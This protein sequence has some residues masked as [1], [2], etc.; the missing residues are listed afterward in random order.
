MN[1]IIT[2]LTWVA[3]FICSNL[4]AQPLSGVKTIGGMS[5]D[6]INFTA[7]INS[8]NTNGVGTGGVVFDVAAGHVDTAINLTITATGT[9]SNPIVI[10]KSG[11]GNNPIIYAGLGTS[12]TTDGIL[13]LSGTDYITIDGIDFFDHP[14][15]NTSNTTRMEWG[16]AILKASTSNGCQ[17]VVIRNCNFTLQKLNTASKAIY[18]ANHTPTS[19][20]ALTISALSGINANIEI[21]GNTITNSFSAIYF[22][23]STNATYFDDSIRIGSLGRNI[24][25]DFGGSGTAYGV[26]LQY[27]KNAEIRND[28]IYQNITPTASSTHYGIYTGTTTN[29]NVSIAQNAVTLSI[30]GSQSTRAVFPI[31]VLSG[32]AGNVSTI[33][34]N[35]ITNTVAAA[36][37]TLFSAI[38]TS[39]N[40]NTFIRGNY[41][42]GYSRIGTSGNTQIIYSGLNP[43]IRE[44][45]GNTILNITT[46][47][48][49]AQLRI[50]AVPTGGGLVANNLINTTNSSGTSADAWIIDIAGNCQFV[51]NQISNIQH[52]SSST[53][54]LFVVFLTGGNATV[55]D[56]TINTSSTAGGLF[57]GIEL[58]GASGTFYQVYR[59]K[60]FDFSSTY[61]S[62]VVSAIRQSNNN[63]ATIFNN[64]IGS[65]ASGPSSTTANG[66]N[67]INCS[68][69]GNAELKL[70]HNTIYLNATSTG[71][72]NCVLLNTSANA[73]LANNLF[74]NLSA[75]S[76]TNARAACA[77]RRT[78]TTFN[79]YNDSS[80]NNYFYV[81][82]TPTANRFVY[83]DG[84]NAHQTIEQFQA[85]AINRDQ[86][87]VSS[88]LNFMSVSGLSP[89][90]LKPVD[91]CYIESAGKRIAGING[92][93][94]DT[95]SRNS[96]PLSGQLNG[97]GLF[98]DIGAYEL[99]LLFLDN[100]KPSIVYTPITRSLASPSKAFDNVSITDVSGIN[101][102]TP[103][104]VYFKKKSN[105][106]VLAATNSALDN[107]WK[108]TSTFNTGSPFSF[109]LDYS[110]LFPNGTVSAGDT[111]EYFIVA[112]DNSPLNNTA[113][114]GATLSTQPVA[115]ALAQAQFPVSNAAFYPILASSIS[116]IITVGTSFAD[117]SSLTL[118][119]G[120]FDAINNGIVAGDITAVVIT[121]L[122]NETGQ[123]A[124]NRFYE[125]G[126]APGT[127]KLTI[128][129]VSSTNYTIS[130]INTT[131]GIL[132]FNDTRRV[133]INGNVSGFTR[134]FTIVNN[135]TTG[136][137]AAIQI[138]GTLNGGG[139]SDIE[140]IG[141]NLWTENIGT[142]SSVVCIGGTTVGTGTG[143]N[144][145]VSNKRITI[146]NNSIAKAYNG[147]LVNGLTGFWADSIRIMNN[148]IG[149]DTV[150][151]YLLS[152]GI[153]IRGAIRTGIYGNRIF[154][155]K[156]SGT[157]TL[158][159]INLDQECTFT[160]VSANS[161]EKI[162]NLAN[163]AVPV[164]GIYSR[165]NT[166]AN[167]TLRNNRISSIL[168]Q[169]GSGDISVGPVGI[170]F[171]NGDNSAIVNNTVLLGGTRLDNTVGNAYTACL[172][173]RSPV[174]N[175]NVSN[176][177][178]KNVMNSLNT[179]SAGN[180]FAIVT[181]ANNA[182]AFTR[183]DNNVYFVNSTTPGMVN[184]LA[185]NNTTTRTNLSAWRSFSN[186]D[187]FSLWGNAPFL[188]DST[189]IVVPSDSNAWLMNGRGYPFDFNGV[190]YQ[191]NSRSSM[192]TTGAVDIGADEF[193]PSVQPPVATASAIPASGQTTY[194]SFGQDTIAEIFWNPGGSVPTDLTIRY[195]S[196]V[197][198][199]SVSNNNHLHTYWSMSSNTNSGI[200]YN[201]T[202]YYKPESMNGI[203]I[204]SLLTL[205]SYSNSQWYAYP[206]ASRVVDSGNKKFTTFNLL[207]FTTFT[208]TD[209][210]NPLP[211]KLLD[212][213]AFLNDKN[214]VKLNW[215]T[216]QHQNVNAFQVE[217]GTD[218]KLFQ[219]IGVI[220]VTES[221]Y[222]SL[223]HYEYI[224]QYPSQLNYYRLK[225]M[226][227]DGSFAYSPIV[228]VNK[229]E[230]SISGEPVVI[231]PVPATNQL[232]IN[233]F[234]SSNTKVSVYNQFGQL[235]L[236]TLVQP[237]AN[238]IDISDLAEGIY[239]ISLQAKDNEVISKK[240]I[241]VKP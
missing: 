211:L 117:Y 188:N 237:N 111:I 228:V 146:S 224:H 47:G 173:V 168:G 120:L 19:T 14:T 123:I 220:P 3:L 5:P 57:N 31:Y 63:S 132:R 62:C 43:V 167:I 145:G 240:I 18:A 137:N 97:G 216:T 160:D 74:M 101:T 129:P 204:D 182:T 1:R 183:I 8:L 59:N 85:Y 128:Q 84:T 54:E 184:A 177:V 23:G 83:T 65:I 223:S 235:V 174:S 56:N 93:F 207:D 29:A 139:A 187:K 21:H 100:K 44:I 143:A 192:M 82:A 127:Y 17:N 185:L 225:I 203:A 110:L 52:N 232:T 91:T 138:M 226:D 219:P 35:R 113:V 51:K 126:T 90:F 121:D 67:G 78:S 118:P 39:T 61:S 154:N 214:E 230:I 80:D 73:L 191:S 206:S 213:T 130:G 149:T 48:T 6:F 179:I 28:S 147:I 135:A 108:F 38:Y 156:N 60:I 115:V 66:I 107:G 142:G 166:N 75:N 136:A 233:N 45:T 68:A 199:P 221:A 234:A 41:I 34:S 209:Y 77:L 148:E 231:Y 72:S 164:F 114:S 158:S 40:S 15:M 155:I 190:D 4:F 50:I 181:S 33:D 42:D 194:Y 165:A 95:L 193:T 32:A 96:Y 208:G 76:S 170:Y 30:N 88:I 171:N 218:G 162:I 227:N 27:F 195:H 86:A 22:S 20:S 241:K 229:S 163:A 175:L 198:P 10:Q 37:S 122:P 144:Q 70:Y 151:K 222:N 71:G 99:D 92:D 25:T 180:N 36:S 11:S 124:L 133:T 186:K 202:L 215:T 176:N 157:Q 210:N 16:V 105:A 2:S 169:G 98:P 7:A 69:S 153:F 125:E 24:I 49:S 81:S 131:G 106:N 64:L 189:P 141:C 53:G 178:F 201:L 196:G 119:G 200:N 236:T 205:A 103:P 87:S 94:L 12:T 116:S 102:T 152:N 58:A 140:I 150:S 112:A 239:W 159:G 89:N 104:R 79:S 161:I 109:T 212:F 217:H 172:Y 55:A 46:S 134:N 13:K 238:T 197:N 26:Y 9:A